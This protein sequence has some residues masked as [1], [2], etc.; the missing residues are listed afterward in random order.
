MSDAILQAIQSKLDSLDGKV[1]AL[2]V[3]GATIYER[4]D[5]LKD[6][7]EKHL[8]SDD[9]T[10]KK[11]GE[12]INTL[13]H[14]KTSWVSKAGSVAAAVAVVT[15]VIVGTIVAFIKDAIAGP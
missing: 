3:Q 1:D 8:A 11:L 13:E 9:E 10:H 6:T 7:V 5:N 4:V 12:R 2:Q 14:W 15:S